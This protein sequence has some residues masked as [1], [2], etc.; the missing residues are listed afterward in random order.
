MKNSKNVRRL[1]KLPFKLL[2][3]FMGWIIAFLGI[4]LLLVQ[5]TKNAKKRTCGNKVLCISHVAI[6][7]DGRIKKSANTIS[8]LGM[9]VTLL[10]PVDAQE[11][12]VLEFSG[13]NEKVIVRPMGLSGVFSHFPCIFDLS[14]FFYILCSKAR[15]LHCHDINTVFMGLLAAKFTGQ[16]IVSDLHEWKS[17]TSSVD[18][19]NKSIFFLQKKIYQFV[20]K[21]TLQNADFIIS[22]NEMIAKEM[23]L[24]YKVNCDILIVKNIPD[25]YD[26]KPY[27]LRERLSIDARFLLVYYVGQL[28]PYRNIDEILIAISQCPDIAF[29]LQG[30]IQPCYQRSLKKKCSDLKISDRVFFLPPVSHDLIP[31]ACQGADVGIF[32][33]HAIG[34]SMYYSLPNKLFEY[35]LGGIPI[36]AEDLPV[37]RSYVIDNDIGTIVN[38]KIPETIAAVLMSYLRNPNRLIVQKENVLSLRLK[39]IKNDENTLP[40]KLIYKKDI[41]I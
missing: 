30:T 9:E 23:K 6:S 5:K 12:S 27:D 17:E 34:K 15:Y 37:V 24:F 38:S 14:M 18:R 20:E 25:F 22:V 41:R 33:C 36:I 40:Y 16:I 26:L 31:S 1:L 11:D 13:L 4:F 8:K 32:T 39:L 7:F 3:L 29:V 2:Y 21:L 35:I 28:A 10:K 19:K